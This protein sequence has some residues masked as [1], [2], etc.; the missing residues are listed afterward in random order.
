MALDVLKPVKSVLRRWLT[1]VSDADAIFEVVL[2]LV[3]ALCYHNALSCD[4]VY[5]DEQA[6]INNADVRGETGVLNLFSNDFWGRPIN[7][8]RG[9]DCLIST[10]LYSAISCTL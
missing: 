3:V 7:V 8:V 9:F 2:S 5:D 1:A 4:F 6:V 10:Q